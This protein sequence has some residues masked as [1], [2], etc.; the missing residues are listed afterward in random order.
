MG[1][2]WCKRPERK[3][4]K[5]LFRSRQLMRSAGIRLAGIRLAGIRL[6]GIRL[7]VGLAIIGIVVGELFTAISGLWNDCRIRERI[8][9]GKAICVGHRHC[10][11]RHCPDR[12]R[13]LISN[14]TCLAGEFQNVSVSER[15]GLLLKRNLTG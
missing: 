5:R 12:N 11:R 2:A 13:G 7:S 15:V 1:I 9:Y 6:A 14:V 10:D 3:S 4:P 8:R